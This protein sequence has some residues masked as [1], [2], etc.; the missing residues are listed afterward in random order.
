VDVTGAVFTDNRPT[1]IAS[2]AFTCTGDPGTFCTA[3]GPLAPTDNIGDTVNIPAGKQI[4]YTIVAT[5]GSCSPCG[6]LT[7]RADISVPTG[8]TDP[9]ASNNTASDTDLPPSAD[10]MVTLTDHSTTFTPGGTNT[11]IAVVTNN[12][13][14]D[15]S[16]AQF[17]IFTPIQVNGTT[18]TVTCTPDLGAGCS[19]LATTTSIS[20]LA[21]IIPAGKKVTYTIAMPILN[22]TTGPMTVTAHIATPGSLDDPVAANNYA[23]DTDTLSP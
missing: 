12:G 4:T 19:P 22:P 11:F 23:T 20:D 16:L 18:W 14:S 17:T 5:I 21:V 9:V 2:W 3:S 1:L 10:L 15:V 8:I 13:P 7:N 6:A